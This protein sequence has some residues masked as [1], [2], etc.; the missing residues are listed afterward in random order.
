MSVNKFLCLILYN[1]EHENTIRYVVN[2]KK[3]LKSKHLMF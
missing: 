2:K 3:L 1:F